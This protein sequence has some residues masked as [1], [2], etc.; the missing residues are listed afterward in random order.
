MTTLSSKPPDDQLVLDA[1]GFIPEIPRIPLG[2]HKSN[3][4]RAKT[5]VDRAVEIWHARCKHDK[6]HV[7][8]AEIVQSP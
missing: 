7:A 5:A 2:Q 4:A 6:A 3:I 8:A 1:L